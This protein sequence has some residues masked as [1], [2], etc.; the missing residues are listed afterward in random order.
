MVKLIESYLESKKG[1]P[2][3]GED[4]LVLGPYYFGC[5]DGATD[6]SGKNWNHPG[7]HK[8]GGAAIADI[9]KKVLEEEDHALPSG[10]ITVINRRIHLAA[11][12]AGIDLADVRNRADASFAMY[13]PR[14]DEIWHTGD[15]E[16]VCYDSGRQIIIQSHNEKVLDTITGHTR[17][18]INQLC[19]R[20]D[21]DPFANGGDIG[22][23]YVWDLM[24]RRTEIQNI[25]ENVQKDWIRGLPIHLV[26]YDIINGFSETLEVTEVPEHATE[27]VITSDGFPR[28][29]RTLK[30][31]TDD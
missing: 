6:F 29:Y 31:T 28:R 10:L 5:I 17:A 30:Q 25:P 26:K 22:R 24:E 1:T 16:F 19:L 15:C 18:L 11:N 4:R 14:T 13:K 20:K 7:K 3:G 9:I 21:I 12:R 27:I 8:K 23:T 2:D